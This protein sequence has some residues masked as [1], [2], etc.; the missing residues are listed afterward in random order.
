MNTKGLQSMVRTLT[1]EEAKKLLVEALFH[2][3]C[4]SGSRNSFDLS[5]YCA[6]FQLPPR[7]PGVDRMHTAAAQFLSQHDR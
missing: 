6:E 4:V 3:R 1:E 5:D 7:Q 2:L